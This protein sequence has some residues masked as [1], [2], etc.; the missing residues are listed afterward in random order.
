ML[1]KDKSK[2]NVN[3]QTQ[4]E[5]CHHDTSRIGWRMIVTLGGITAI[6]NT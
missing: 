6:S 4:A 3:Y 1:K 2:N 5:L